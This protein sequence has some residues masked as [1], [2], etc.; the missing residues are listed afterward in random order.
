MIFAIPAFY[1]VAHTT[2]WE[3]AV[4]MLGIGASY[5]IVLVAV[6]SLSVLELGE[7]YW[8]GAVIRRHLGWLIPALRGGEA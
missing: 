2:R 3:G 6:V 1:C 8:F 7:R 4:L 5:S